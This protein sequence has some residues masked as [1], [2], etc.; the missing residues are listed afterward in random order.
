LP[1]TKRFVLI[2]ALAHTQKNLSESIFVQ[3]LYLLAYIA[4][5]GKVVQKSKQLNK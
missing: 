3:N 4:V 2:R 1:A 5:L